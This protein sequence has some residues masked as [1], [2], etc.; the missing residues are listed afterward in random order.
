MIPP[1]FC[2]SWS[3]PAAVV[4]LA[5][6]GRRALVGGL[7]H[8]TA[9][10]WP[11]SISTPIS[12]SVTP[13]RVLGDDPPLVHDEDA[14]GEREHLLELERDEEDR[15]S[16]VALLDEPP[17]EV[18]DRADVETARRLR[19]DEHARVAIDLTRGDELLLV[20]AREVPRLRLRVAAA[21]VELLDQATRPLDE[22]LGSKPAEPRVRRVAEV[23]QGGVLREREVE[24]EPVAMAVLR[25]VADARL[26]H[27][28]RA[29]A[30][31]TSRVRPRRCGRSRACAGR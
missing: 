24:D 18:L 1:A 10:R 30:A 16:H 20:P 3:F 14:V 25:N 31:T 27:R 26:E 2:L 15:A 22:H 4:G 17:V 29:R 12:S 9:S 6:L 7:R 19:G 5:L 23:V 21:H 8:A 11:P 13:E 28:Q